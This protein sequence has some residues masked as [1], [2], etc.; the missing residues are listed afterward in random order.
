[1]VKFRSAL[2]Q[3]FDEA[4]FTLLISDYFAPR[5]FAGISPAGFGKDM[6]FR[7]YEV[8]Q[9][10]RMEDWLFDLVA[11]AYERRPRNLALADIATDLGLTLRG[12]RLDN[13]TGKPLEDII[14]DNAKFINL[15]VFREKLPFLE[16]RVCWVDIP[17]FGGTGFLVGPD[18][19]LTNQHVIERLQKKP[20]N[21]RWQDVKCRFDYKQDINGKPLDQKKWIE[22]GLNVS[23]PIVHDWPPS[24]FDFNPNLGD[25]DLVDID[26]ALLRL[27]VPLGDLPVGPATAD[28][29]APL[30]GWIDAASAPP[31]LVQGNQ[32]FLLQHPKGQPL[33][34]AI[35]EITEFNQ[36]G[37]RVRYNANSE[38]GSSGSPVF[39]ADLQLVAVHH[40]HDTAKP[41]RWNQAVPFDCIQK[42][43]HSDAITFMAPAE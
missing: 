24:P 41:R 25:A 38:D 27:A 12:H 20:S 16:S 39:N 9:K 18:L 4:S 30:R 22:I 37:T 2:D 42:V 28:A 31:P 35:G 23:K 33:Q 7:L 14:Q 29:N 15:A 40:A 43:C 8:I 6:G 32:I 36:K 21:A 17:G 19:V 11:A 1:M 5:T 13:P 10:A 34:L 26:I 3:A